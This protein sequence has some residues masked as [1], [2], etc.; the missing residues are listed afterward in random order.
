MSFLKDISHIA[1]SVKRGFNSLPSRISDEQKYAAIAS[2]AMRRVH[3]MRPKDYLQGA[4]T[5]AF[6]GDWNSL[7]TSATSIIRTEFKTL[8]ARS[9]QAYR[10]DP[11]ARRALQVLATA[12]VGQGIKPYP[13]IKMA[14][15]ELAE[16]ATNKLAQDWQRYNDQGMRNGSQ[17][18]TVYEGQR[19]EFLTIAVYGNSL[20]NFVNA[21]PGAWLRQSMQIIKPTRLDFGKDSFFG[22][23][24]Y[25]VAPK[26]MIVHGIEINSYGEPVR[27]Y[28]EGVEKPI[29]AKNMLLNYYPIETEAY[30]G[31]PWLTPSLGNIFDNQQIFED[32]LKQSRTLARLGVRLNKKDRDSFDYAAD[33]TADNG[34]SYI[35]LDYQGFVTAEDGSLNA[36]KM[37]DSLRESFNPLV[38]HNLIQLGVGMGFS[39][40]VL[41]SDLEG[42]N[43][44]ASR[45]N[46]IND[47]RHFRTIFKWYTKTVLQR[48]YERFVEMEIFQGRVPGVTYQNY[49]DDPWY[50]TQCYWLPMDGEEWV[51]PL[52]D[53]ESLKLLYGL[54]QV[55]YQEICAMSGKDYRSTY[56]QLKKERDMFKADDM[57]HLMPDLNAG[58]S[59]SAKEPTEEEKKEE[60][61]K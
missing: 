36:I 19:L 56:A 33:T 47:N 8:C 20:C 2:R 23:S 32:K 35:D 9:E 10:T 13:I 40:Q 34:E 25:E 21:R 12:V 43:F 60:I 37:D 41:S 27:F 51:D 54:G 26:E 11:W 5:G 59:I 15:G 7:V 48:R 52:R 17:Q 16:T 22:S 44:A 6:R 31:Y 3:A 57:M 29:D 45:A 30:L 18:L 14:N 28:L 24:N 4:D 46:I 53:A 61:E 55:T 50:Y 58:V 49:L 38:K 42:M 39:Y 1:R